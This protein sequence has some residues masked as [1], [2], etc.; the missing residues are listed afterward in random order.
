VAPLAGT[1]EGQHGVGAG[2]SNLGEV[3][4]RLHGVGTGENRRA[5][6]TLPKLPIGRQE[7]PGCLNSLDI[8]RNGVEDRPDQVAAS[9]PPKTMNAI[10]KGYSRYDMLLSLGSAR[11]GPLALI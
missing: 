9:I 3:G 11:C 5:A 8:R 6:E 7:E 10:A 2:V 1:I 4:T